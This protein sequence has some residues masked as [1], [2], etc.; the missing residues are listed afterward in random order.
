MNNCPYCGSSIQEG[1]FVCTNCGSTITHQ[2]ADDKESQAE[3]SKPQISVSEKLEK[4]TLDKPSFWV[5]LVSFIPIA[6][7]IYFISNRKKHPRKSRAAVIC[8]LIGIPLTYLLPL[9]LSWI[10]TTMQSLGM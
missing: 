9:I 7:I 1:V 5:C 8:A 6:G 3:I 2:Q 10:L 4:K